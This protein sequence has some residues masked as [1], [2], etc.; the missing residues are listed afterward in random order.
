L[1]QSDWEQELSYNS[2]LLIILFGREQESISARN[3]KENPTFVGLSFWCRIAGIFLTNTNDEVDI[4][5]LK[6]LVNQFNLS[7]GLFNDY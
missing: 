4:Y 6:E 2:R 5:K 3:Q 7:D 1:T